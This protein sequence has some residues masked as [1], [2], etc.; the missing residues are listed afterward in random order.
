MGGNV[1]Q[2]AV[3]CKRVLAMDIDPAKVQGAPWRYYL[4]LDSLARGDRR[5]DTTFAMAQEEEPLEK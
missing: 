2:L 4:R 3:T 1:I 5:H